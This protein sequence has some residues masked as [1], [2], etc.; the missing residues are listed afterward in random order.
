MVASMTAFAH[1]EENTEQYGFSW[2]I[3][4]VNHRYLETYFRLP[5][6]AKS[7]ELE[8]REKI[9]NTLFRGKIECY[10][11]MHSNHQSSPFSL[12]KPLLLQLKDAMQTLSLEIPSL[13]N[14]S[15]LDV[16]NWPGMINTS[17][18]LSA[19]LQEKLLLIFDKALSQIIEMRQQ[20][21]KELRHF[22][23][24][25]IDAIE[26]HI[27]TLRLQMPELIKI[28]TNQIKMRV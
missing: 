27:H 9:K 17:S 10:L 23:T 14:S 7:L 20:E 22:I 25:R 19:S 4:T 28:Y 6:E 15:I 1:A 24:L 5:E 12:N 21:G 16:L 8:L 11:H 13:R 3:K 26:Q 2:E 18:G